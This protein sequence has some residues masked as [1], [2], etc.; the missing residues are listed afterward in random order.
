M[1]SDRIMVCLVRL[2]IEVQAF[3]SVDGKNRL[4]MNVNNSQTLFSNLTKVFLFSF[5]L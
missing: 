5:S 3:Y 1:R 2:H 4:H